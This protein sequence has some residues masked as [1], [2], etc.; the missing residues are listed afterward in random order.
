MWNHC[1]KIKQRLLWC[2]AVVTAA[3][4][5]VASVGVAFQGGGAA[6]A[7][8]EVV[9][10][11]EALK[12]IDPLHYK[13]AIYLEPL[14]QIQLTAPVS[15]TVQ[16]VAIRLGQREAKGAEAFRLDNAQAA[17]QVRKVRAN[18]QAAR[19]DKKIADARKDPDLGALAEAR[20]EAAQA[21]VEMAEVESQRLVIRMPFTAQ[22]VKIHAPE[23]QGVR[24]G[25]L[26]ATIAEVSKL[27][28]EVPVEKSNANIGGTIEINIEQHPVKARIEAVLPLSPRFDV[29]RDLGDELVSVVVGIDNLDSRYQARQT[30]RTSL[31][32]IDPVAVVSTTTVSNESEGNRKVQVLRD[33]VVRNV[34]IRIL[35][36]IGTERVYI[37]GKF[38]EGDELIVQSSKE[39]TDGTP[40]KSLTS[41]EQKTTGEPTVE[42][43]SKGGPVRLGPARQP[44]QSSKG[45]F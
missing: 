13:V 27:M 6:T 2:L 28:V 23:G 34:P 40:V 14:R 17:L 18:L 19:I 5:S 15:G 25:D 7:G 30:V 42:K 44:T 22:I 10:K 38:R 1:F 39:L 24:A 33:N 21:D 8:S 16:Q 12:L 35:A 41:S 29:L 32:P 31:Q 9:I 43:G 37:S 20:I 45:G 11:R 36:K 3:A 4:A 26:L